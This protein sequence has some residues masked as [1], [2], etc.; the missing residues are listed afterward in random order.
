MPTQLNTPA[1]ESRREGRSTAEIGAVEA[2]DL[3]AAPLPVA[4]LATL[5]TQINAAVA[6]ADAALDQFNRA[7]RRTLDDYA[8]AGQLLL[9][10]KV[11]VEHG[12][13]LPW[14]GEHCP[15]LAGHRGRRA[16]EIMQ[17]ARNLEMIKSA[18]SATLTKSGA[19]ALLSGPAEPEPEAAPDTET[20]WFQKLLDVTAG[21]CFP[22]SR[23]KF[24][25]P[26]RT[27]SSPRQGQAL[28]YLPD[29]SWLKKRN[30]PNPVDVFKQRF[31]EFGAI[32]EVAL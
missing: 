12:Q 28:F 14:L 17:I 8:I 32:V 3:L 1:I 9:T 6:K 25:S 4:S 22:S 13:W 10:A 2:A 11:Q 31:S 15:N 27:S 18:D 16:Q 7:T 19:L 21:V 24:Y 20:E 29:I 30:Q 26:A 5:A 23:I